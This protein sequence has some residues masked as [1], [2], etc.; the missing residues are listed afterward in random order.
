VQRFSIR[1]GAI[2]GALVTALALAGCGSDDPEATPGT[3]GDSTTTAGGTSSA[4]TADAMAT[5]AD[6]VVATYD[7]SIASAGT[8]QAAIEAF[9]ENPTAGTLAAAKDA[10]L[11]ARVD[12]LPTEVYR[13]YDGPIDDPEDGPEGQINAWPMDEAF[14]DYTVDAPNGGIVNDPATF[15]EITTEVLV[16]QNE[17]GGETNI[18][19]GWHAIEFLLWGQDRN[20]GAPGNRP[21]TDYTTGKNAERRAAYLRTATQLLVDDLTAV[22]NEWDPATGA[23]RKT[24]LADPDQALADVLRGIGALSSGEL[25][26]ERIAV[27]LETKDQEDEHSCFSDNTNADIVGDVVG[28]RQVYLAEYEGIDGTSISD[29]VKAVDPALDEKLRGQIE[30]SE[31]LAEALPAPFEDLIAGAD[32]DPGRMALEETLISIEDQGQSI[33]EAANKLGVTITLEV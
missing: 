21:V 32:T 12:Y 26:G 17:K 24:F 3:S 23:Y 29:L 19:T 33:A 31:R 14:V 8:M 5:Y 27:A 15:P 25:A 10:W 22:R 1:R 11:A 30:N 18:S 2:V 16:S 9:L 6:L 28:V 4:D 20:E 7:A 13:F